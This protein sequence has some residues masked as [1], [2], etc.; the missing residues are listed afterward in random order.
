MK[1]VD[2]ADAT[3]DCSDN[4][5]T[6]PLASSAYDGWFNASD[7]VSFRNPAGLNHSWLESATASDAGLAASS[8]TAPGS[9]RSTPSSRRS[10]VSNGTRDW[11]QRNVPVGETSATS[12]S[13]GDP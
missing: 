10:V 2:F 8:A 7:D 1:S 3:P 6:R 11:L 9:D 5:N 12:G 13:S 4:V